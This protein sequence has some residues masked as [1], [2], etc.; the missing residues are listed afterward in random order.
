LFIGAD[1]KAIKK[2]FKNENQNKEKR[3]RSRKLKIYESWPL[4][5]FF[6]CLRQNPCSSRI[7]NLT[8]L[9]T[10]FFFFFFFLLLL[11]LQGLGR[12]K[13]A[14]ERGHGGQGG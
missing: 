10:L 7:C 4:F 13:R 11:L 9:T 1:K 8:P 12:T 6:F 5:S 2:K 14:A 3:E